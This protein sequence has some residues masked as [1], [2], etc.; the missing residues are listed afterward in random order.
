M[1]D[2]VRICV[3]VDG[4]GNVFR[5]YITGIGVIAF[6]ERFLKSRKA[7]ITATVK[8]RVTPIVFLTDCFTINNFVQI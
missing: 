8:T 1:A 6:L 5:L 3:N 4:V 2:A 7:V